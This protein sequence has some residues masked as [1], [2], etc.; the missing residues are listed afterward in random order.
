MECVYVY[1][2][3]FHLML[4][5]TKNNKIIEESP[6]L[7]TPSQTIEYQNTNSLDRR[8][9]FYYIPMYKVFKRMVNDN[10]LRMDCFGGWRCIAKVA[11]PD[12]HA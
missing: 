1:M 8:A 5:N 4:K 3:A 7:P 6:S 2:R 10:P 12:V 9:R 11:S